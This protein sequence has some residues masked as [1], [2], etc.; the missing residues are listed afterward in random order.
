MLQ[1]SPQ[2]INYQT[3]DKDSF[4]IDYECFKNYEFIFYLNG[5]D[6]N[7]DVDKNKLTCYVDKTKFSVSRGNTVAYN[8]SI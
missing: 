1:E 7:Y 8:V 2:Y 3:I 6:I 5:K 4:Q